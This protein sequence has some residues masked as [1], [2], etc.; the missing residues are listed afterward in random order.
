MVK[1]QIL[2]CGSSPR[3]Q[4]FSA[5]ELRLSSFHFKGCTFTEY[6]LRVQFKARSNS[7][8]PWMSSQCLQSLQNHHRMCSSEK[9]SVHL[10][11]CLKLRA[12]T[13]H[14]F[15][16]DISKYDKQ[17]HSLSSWQ[18]WGNNVEQYIVFRRQNHIVLRLRLVA[19]CTSNP[20]KALAQRTGA[21]R[22]REHRNSQE[23]VSFTYGSLSAHF[24]S[25]SSHLNAFVRFDDPKS[26]FSQLQPPRPIKRKGSTCG[27]D[28]KATKIKWIRSA[29]QLPSLL[30]Q[31]PTSFF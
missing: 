19:V 12:L 27:S 30:D 15:N 18:L 14:S 11:A 25:C 31:L 23:H 5:D 4:A 16:L 6:A 9:D 7:S 28:W 24:W 13:R 26:Y 3:K 29:V 17:L 21:L 20:W 10:G 2:T 1:L 8:F 22:P